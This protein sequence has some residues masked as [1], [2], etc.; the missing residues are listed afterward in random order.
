VDVFDAG[1]LDEA[2]IALRTFDVHHVLVE[3]G[4]Q[5]A[6]EFLRRDLVDRLIIFQ[7]PRPLGPDALRPFEGSAAD[8]EAKLQS[9]PVVRSGQFGDDTMT[10]YAIHEA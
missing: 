10:V 5:V 6:R 7:S 8:F 3:G 1:T 4:A 2:L 9:L